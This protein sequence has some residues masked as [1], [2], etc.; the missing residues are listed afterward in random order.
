MY[1]RDVDRRDDLRRRDYD[2][3]DDW[4]RLRDHHDHYERHRECNLDDRPRRRPSGFDNGPPPGT[5]MQSGQPG[6]PQVG[7]MMPGFDV[8]LIMP[9]RPNMPMPMPTTN[10]VNPKKQRELYIGNVR[11]LRRRDARAPVPTRELE[12]KGYNQPHW[13]V[14]AAGADRRGERADD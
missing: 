12:H 13:F 3:R 14:V 9:H 8:A 11:P 7:M 6:M 10:T 2:N 1:V 5:F 4:R